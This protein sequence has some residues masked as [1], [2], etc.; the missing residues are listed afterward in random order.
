MKH[1]HSARPRSRPR[2]TF[3]C[4]TCKR[5]FLIIIFKIERCCLKES[6]LAKQIRA[7]EKDKKDGRRPLRLGLGID[8]EASGLPQSGVAPFAGGHLCA[9]D[10]P[11]RAGIR[12]TL[13]LQWNGW[14]MLW[15]R[16]PISRTGGS[17]RRPR[18]A[19]KSS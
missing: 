1:G 10:S 15:Q 9:P 12:A 18:K 16:P 3:V 17:A 6:H 8:V 19:T 11:S 5:I 2:G 13:S 4:D 7:T 14:K